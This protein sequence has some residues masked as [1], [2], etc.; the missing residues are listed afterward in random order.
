MCVCVCQEEDLAELASQQYYVEYGTE[1]HH[2]RLLTLI[3][4]YIPD[5][6]IDSS[7]TV[8]K[9]AQVIMSTH[10]MVKFYYKS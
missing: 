6:E 9:W 7:R 1:V 5:G 2:D 4:S 3:T 8:E 10:K